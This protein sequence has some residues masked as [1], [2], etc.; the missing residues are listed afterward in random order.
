MNSGIWLGG[1]YLRRYRVHLPNVKFDI[2]DPSLPKIVV[3]IVIPLKAFFASIRNKIWG[4]S[5]ESKEEQDPPG[6]GAQGDGA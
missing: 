6:G 5:A 4:F 2:Q 1:L 3:N